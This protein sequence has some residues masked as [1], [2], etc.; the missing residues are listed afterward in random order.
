MDLAEDSQQD[1]TEQLCAV[2][3]QAAA[4]HTSAGAPQV[5]GSAAAQAEGHQNPT[6]AN[7]GAGGHGRQEPLR[8]VSRSWD[9]RQP[10]G[11]PSVQV[12]VDAMRPVKSLYISLHSA[13]HQKPRQVSPAD[14]RKRVV[15]CRSQPFKPAQWSCRCSTSSTKR[16]TRHCKG[17]L[18]RLTSVMP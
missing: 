4:P 14:S 17:R 3:L 5:T 1:P 12:V 13:C 6:V 2:V 18:I 10:H 15:V 8:V 11:Q 9:A 7:S 16:P